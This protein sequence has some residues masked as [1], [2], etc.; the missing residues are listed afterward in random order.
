V[1]PDEYARYDGLGLAEL[2]RKGEVDPSEVLDCALETSARTN[3]KLNA[4][5]LF[6]QDA[7]RRELV[8]LPPGPFRGVP[9]P[10]KD[11]HLQIPGEVTTNGCALFREA[12]APVESTLIARYRAAGLVLFAR[13]TSPEFGLTLSTE[14]ALWGPTRNPWDFS[15]MA[16]GSSGGAAAAVA[17]GIAPLANASD[18]G[19]S[20]RIPASCCGL[21]GLKPT[22]M[23]TPLGP[24]RAEGWNGLTSVHAITRSV[25]DS[26]ALLDA[27]AGPE[28][29]DP[30]WAPPPARPYL[31]EV[32]AP[33]GRLR[34]ALVRSA[35]GV[36]TEPECLRAVEDAAK[37]CEELGHR[38][39]E[40]AP[41]L[42]APAIARAMFATISV[43]TRVALEARAADLG[44]PLGET[45]VEP[46][47][48]AMV[49]GA[50]RTTGLD[51][52]RARETILRASRDMARFQEEWDLILS[53]TLAREPLPLG[54]CSLS[55]RDLEAYFREIASVSPFSSIANVTGQ[56]AMSVP[57]HWSASGLPIGVMFAGRFGDE[58]TLFRLAGQL[59]QA[60]PWAGRR[61]PLEV[62]Q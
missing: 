27:T 16:G 42:D 36:A 41:A 5:I 12:R 34:V 37:L 56:P 54:V 26:A 9:F 40:A 47:T 1:R 53:P 4:L 32:G 21:F 23:R 15:R 20:I 51:M 17:A 28:L 30:Y 38:V 22:R 25:R 61:P 57:L 18:G 24:L 45:D 29:G 10:I 62:V 55:R 46:V 44:R 7:A 13:S 60:R 14:S 58:A 39:E 11:L 43:A 6:R 8:S 52:L 35:G 33:P 50:L 19:G 59:E 31:R 3:P 48:W 49:E 2:M